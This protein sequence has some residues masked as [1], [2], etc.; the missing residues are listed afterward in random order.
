M[1]RSEQSGAYT[2]NVTGVPTGHISLHEMNI[3]RSDSVTGL[4]KPYVYKDSNFSSFRAVTVDKYFSQ[5]AYGD[6]IYGIYPMSS[7][8][9]RQKFATG[10]GPTGSALQNTFNFYRPLSPHYEY[11]SSIFG[12]NKGDQPCNLIKV[13]S[14]F[15]GSSI[16]KGS[17]SLKYYMTGTLI[18]ELNDIHKNGELVQV[19]PVGS[20]NSGSV[21]GVILYNEGFF[22]LTGAWSLYNAAG[23]EVSLD[24]NND[25]SPVTTTWQHFCNGCN[26]NV[27]AGDS[28]ADS[29]NHRA[30]A[31]FAVD[32]D[33][34]SYVPV[35]TMLAHAPIAEFNHSN[36][37]TYLEYNQTA[38]LT[39]E[40][41]TYQYIE[42]DVI[43]KNVVSSSYEDPTGSFEK[44]TY[45]SK[46]GIYDEN[47][48]LIGMASMATPVKK[49]QDRE[50]TF[51]LK[52]DL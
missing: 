8:I 14:I 10:L 32:F 43:I 37:L 38:A 20:N 1:Y 23:A 26:D 16:K 52:L 29:L 6:K 19:G 39:P 41:G 25:N 46:V 24:Y 45:I 31:S 22:H 34:V 5:H 12:G 49:T 51:K 15:Y 11:T 17:V 35:I 27:P 40:T 36:N 4:I 48:N 2:D 18:G 47:K 13:P 30:S 33:G 9:I 44:T 3:D 21:A 50:Y 28:P 42:N 7:S